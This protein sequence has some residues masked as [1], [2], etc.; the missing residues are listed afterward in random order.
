MNTTQEWVSQE[1][2]ISFR[3]FTGWISKDRLPDVVQ[4]LSIAKALDTTVEYLVTGTDSGDPWIRENI[5]FIRHLKELTPE[6]LRLQKLQV[7]AI[8]DEN[9]ISKLHQADQTG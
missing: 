3:T 9:R 1:S 5:E 6:Q 4:A 8:A 2:G 7:K